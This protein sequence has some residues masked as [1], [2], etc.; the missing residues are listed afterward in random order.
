MRKLVRIV[1]IA[2]A[3]VAL[4]F[5]L[6]KAQE[7]ALDAGRIFEEIMNASD[8]GIPGDLFAKAHCVVLVPNMTKGGFIV[9]AKYGRG[10]IS[11]R[12]PEG[13]GWTAPA[14]MRIEGGSVGFQIGVNRT[15]LVL[16]LM[17]AS[18]KSKLLGSKFTLGGD[19][20]VAG[21]PVGRTAQA[22]TD[23]QMTAEILSYSRSRGVF[24]GV[25][26]EGA[27]LRSDT[28]EDT[29]LYGRRVDPREILDG[30]VAAP[31]EVQPLL[32]TL[33]KYSSQEHR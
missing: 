6:N 29:D 18:G 30:K 23:A 8:G 28:S 17:N 10:V 22:Q 32:D 3:S 31:K 33:T 2:A 20:S 25:S 13:K 7:R 16:L 12:G 27:T 11:C 15:D 4:A 1:V 21:G 24:A 26:L 19:A 5:A 9:G 14:T